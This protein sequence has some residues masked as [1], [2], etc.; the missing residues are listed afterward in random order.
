AQTPDSRIR[1]VLQGG[2]ECLAREQLA[3]D[4]HELQ[5]AALRIRGRDS[6]KK[7]HRPVQIA[8]RMDVAHVQNE[9]ARKP[10]SA[11]KVA[12]S[13]RVFRSAE[14]SRV[15]A[16]IDPK[17]SGRIDSVHPQDLASRD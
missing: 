7:R 1:L 4:Q 10:I 2:F 16:K 14:G 17:D 12:E 9:A 3:P 15:H 5:L 6:A 8:P 13:V 11:A